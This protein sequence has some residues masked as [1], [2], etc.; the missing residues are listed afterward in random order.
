M[1]GEVVVAVDPPCLCLSYRELLGAARSCS[2][3][4]GWIQRCLFVVEVCM[5]HCNY[6]IMS[7]LQT[8]VVSHLH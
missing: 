1:A 7:A 2:V 3:V 6:R 4:L 5:P 8:L